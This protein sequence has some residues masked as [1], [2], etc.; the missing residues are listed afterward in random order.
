MTTPHQQYLNFQEINR[1][2]VSRGIKE[3]KVYGSTWRLAQYNTLMTSRQYLYYRTD[4][5]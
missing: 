1:N 4:I 5:V 3:V 2:V